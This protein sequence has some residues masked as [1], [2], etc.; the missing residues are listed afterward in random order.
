MDP[1]LN[2]CESKDELET[3]R[4]LSVEITLPNLNE[5]IKDMI[6]FKP[7]CLQSYKP[8]GLK[9]GMKNNGQRKQMKLNCG[10]L[11]L[12]WQKTFKGKKEIRLVL[13]Y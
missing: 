6:C 13:M 2:H 12:Q 4:M 9:K 7:N 5:K 1:D 8:H 11:R 10:S 3:F